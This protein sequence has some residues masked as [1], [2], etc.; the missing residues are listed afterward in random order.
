MRYKVIGWTNNDDE[1]YPI[2]EENS[3]EVREAIIAD[4]RANKYVFTGYDHHFEYTCTPVLNNGK[5]V[6][7]GQR[8]WG[9]VMAEAHGVDD[10]DG[11]AYMFYHLRCVEEKRL[12]PD[13]VDDSAII[14]NFIE[15]ISVVKD[16][17]APIEDNPLSE[18]SLKMSTRRYEL[19]NL[20][21]KRFF[22]EGCTL[23]ELAEQ[24]NNHP[25]LVASMLMQQ[26]NESGDKKSIKNALY[27]IYA[28]TGGW[29]NNKRSD[30]KDKRLDRLEKKFEVGR[31]ICP[32][33]EL[34]PQELIPKIKELN[35]NLLPIMAFYVESFMV[36]DKWLEDENASEILKRLERYFEN[37]FEYGYLY[38]IDTLV[39]DVSENVMKDALEALKINGKPCYDALDDEL[40]EQYARLQFKNKHYLTNDEVVELAVGSVYHEV[41]ENGALHL[42]RCRKEQMEAYGKLSRTL[43]EWSGRTNG[44]R[45]EF[46][47]DSKYLAF[48]VVAGKKL[49]LFI[50][51]EKKRQIEVESG[52]VF[53]WCLDDRE[54]GNRVTIIYP[55]HEAGVISSLALEEGAFYKRYE[56]TF[57]KKILFIGDSITQGWNTIS[58]SNSYAYQVSLHYDADSVIFGVG[59]AYFHESILPSEDTYRP[60][61]VI[62]AFGANDYR[63]GIEALDKN[64]R[65]F[66]DRL[67]VIYKDSQI[68]G[69]TPIKGRKRH[70]PEQKDP[71][72]EL[73]TAIYKEYNIVCIDGSNMVSE[74][75]ENYADAYHPN[76]KGYTEMASKLIVELDKLI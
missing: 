35:G 62:V 52:T 5:R 19:I 74:L 18:K 70:S 54:G 9:G 22:N 7:Y 44:V 71:F 57:G 33:V 6:C 40:N 59:G 39:T 32:I 75:D 73:I 42:Y 67:L 14:K 72:R 55:S 10:W 43:G 69:L 30:V 68:I 66:L 31:V 56:H 37:L 28:I 50:N 45:L 53:N 25:A 24:F 48:T 12:P 47:T 11:R 64:M 8:A 21:A 60:D 27:E 76:D 61:V 16:W 17:D 65:K 63:R 29:L 46:V 13:Y 38:D 26:A 51:G 1:N 4:I 34:C 20:S 58:D 23:V 2:M 49:E 3:L 15:P 36:C 41:D